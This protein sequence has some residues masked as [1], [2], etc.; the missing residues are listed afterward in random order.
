MPPQRSAS[1][2]VVHSSRSRRLHP[3][4]AHRVWC[5]LLAGRRQPRRRRSITRTARR[6]HIATEKNGEWLF[7]Q[8]IRDPRRVSAIFI[9]HAAR[10][11][12]VYSESDL[13]NTREIDGWVDVLTM[14]VAPA[15]LD[16]LSPSGKTRTVGDIPFLQYTGS[17]DGITQDVWWSS[18][19]LFPWAFTIKDAGGSTEF[20]V[21]QIVTGIDNKVL[22]TPSLRFPH[23]RLVDWLTRWKGHINHDPFVPITR[24]FD[25][26]RCDRHPAMR[27]SGDGARGHCHLRAGGWHRIYRLHR[28]A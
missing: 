21:E 15:A 14:G 5:F 2:R 11:L 20:T 26:H 17:K 1:R 24:V 16:A 8:N 23:Y 12:I 22:Q 9:D 10:S 25:S 4:T 27:R 13:R 28:P 19:E 18:A 7:E 6:I 3:L